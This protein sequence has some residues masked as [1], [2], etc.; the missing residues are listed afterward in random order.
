MDHTHT[1]QACTVLL[2]WSESF[3]IASCKHAIDLMSR[4]QLCLVVCP[5]ALCCQS[6]IGKV[7]SSVAHHNNNTCQPSPGA[8]GS[9]MLDAVVIVRRLAWTDV[10]H[11]CALLLVNPQREI[12]LDAQQDTP[13][14]LSW[15]HLDIY[16]FFKWY[17]LSCWRMLLRCYNADDVNSA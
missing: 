17:T 2:T 7:Q 5:S 6:L 11:T 12:N 3:L 8:C 1:L 13:G 15:A 16:G 4:S 9:L 10:W 14:S